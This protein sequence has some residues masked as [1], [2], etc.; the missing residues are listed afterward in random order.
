VSISFYA[1]VGQQKTGGLAFQFSLVS[2]DLFHWV[3]VIALLILVSG[4]S[5][6]FNAL[7]QTPPTGGH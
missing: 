1:G 4:K 3:D 5:A 7:V 2:P 6:S